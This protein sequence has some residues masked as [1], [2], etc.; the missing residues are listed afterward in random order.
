MRKYSGHIY[1]FVYIKKKE[2]I[3][4]KNSGGCKGGLSLLHD[5]RC[6]VKMEGGGR[7]KKERVLVCPT[8]NRMGEVV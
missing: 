1:I 6:R 7:R 4:E 5:R 2:K 3:E 8:F